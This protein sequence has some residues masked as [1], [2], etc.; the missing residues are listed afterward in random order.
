MFAQAQADPAMAE[1]L[2]AMLTKMARLE[3]NAEFLLNSGAHN[4]ILNIMKTHKASCFERFVL[5][6][7]SQDTH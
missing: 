5:L 3:D 1:K 6:F 2:L 7:N 4:Q